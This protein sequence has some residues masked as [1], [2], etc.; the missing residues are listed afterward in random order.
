[1]P[2]SSPD[3]SAIRTVRRGVAPTA[4]RMRIASSITATPEELSLAL[5]LACQV[6][7]WAPSITSSWARSVPG[8]SPRTFRAS[9]AAAPCRFRTSSSMVTGTA[10]RRIRYIRL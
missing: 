9:L 5:G 10:R 4:F 7:K 1:M 3:Q 6:S 8:I 2:C